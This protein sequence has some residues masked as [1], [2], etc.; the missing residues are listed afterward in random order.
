M[1]RLL[2]TELALIESG[3]Y[4]RSVREPWKPKSMFQYSVACINHWLVPE[5]VPDKC[6]GC[7]LLDFVP[8]EHKNE[9]A[10]CHF[11]PLNEAGETVQSLEQKG[12]QD[13]LEKVVSEWLR[14]TIKRLKE[15][16]AQSE[17]MSSESAEV[18]Y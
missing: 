5:H 7:L 13:R 1:I 14:A 6:E 15:E 9:E 11:I 12:D 4:G 17:Q 3:G 10:A 8:N 2:E 16:Q 18:T